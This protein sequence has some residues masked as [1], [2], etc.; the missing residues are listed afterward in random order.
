MKG[1]SGK[2][3]S[4]DI[5]GLVLFLVVVMALA[6][7]GMSV[8]AFPA[9]ITHAGSGSQVNI[10]NV[11]DTNGG[12]IT[13]MN[14]TEYLGNTA[15][16]VTFIINRTG[17]GQDPILY[18]DVDEAAT[19]SSCSVNSKTGSVGGK[20][21]YTIPSGGDTGCTI[22][23]GSKVSMMI[24]LLYGGTDYYHYTN[25]TTDLVTASMSATSASSGAA[26]NWNFTVDGLGPIY[27]NIGLNL[28]GGTGGILANT[29]INSP[30]IRFNGSD[31]VASILSYVF[32]INQSGGT[33][34]ANTTGTNLTVSSKFTNASLSGLAD[35]G[36]YNV[37]LEV[38]DNVSNKLNSSYLAFYYDG[39]APTRAEVITPAVNKSWITS[40]SLI[41]NLT[42]A[43]G[44]NLN[45]T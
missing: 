6:V 41:L 3:G 20:Y 2:K 25:Y 42:D 11:T 30:V 22:I 32:Y 29:W 5:K 18:Y 9:G 39:T 44:N 28:T 15:F 10:T 27:S 33:F 43:V 37:T 24:H 1:L 17:V 8:F 12:F 16:N 23:D 7:F 14:N 35:G 38:S 31:A 34:L 21:W 26:F 40:M 45:Y 19:S 13:N 36:F 4:S